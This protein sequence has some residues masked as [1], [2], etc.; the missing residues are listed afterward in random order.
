VPVPQY[1]ALFNPVLEAIKKLGGSAAIAELDEEVTNNLR[2][3][4]EDIAEPHDDRKTEL[5]Y[6]LAWARTYL[7]AFGMLDNSGRG[8]WVLTEKGRRLDSVD[9]RQVARYVRERGKQ[10]TSEDSVVVPGAAKAADVAEAADVALE[11]TWREKLLTTLY[12][13]PPDAFERLC[14]RLL[15]ESGFVRVKVT[16]KSGDGGIDGVGI[17]QLGGLLSFPILFQCKRYRGSVGAGTIRDFRGAMIGRADRSLVI[18]TGTFS[19]EARA[20][21]TRDGAPPIDLL[22]GEQLLDKLKELQLGVAVKMIEEVTVLPE[23]FKAI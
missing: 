6:R 17:V 7:K 22:D 12:D 9:P 18:T 11:Q 5:Q 14:Q 4:A 8:V 20:E 21:A 19:R 3:T 10:P 1:T 13:L 23:W 16:G 15:R 2:L